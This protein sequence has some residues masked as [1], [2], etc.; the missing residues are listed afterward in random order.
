MVPTAPEPPLE[1]PNVTELGAVVQEDL[2]ILTEEFGH[3]TTL[4]DS[5]EEG[6][7]YDN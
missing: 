4:V 7:K 2:S 3:P 6:K 1:L 5:R